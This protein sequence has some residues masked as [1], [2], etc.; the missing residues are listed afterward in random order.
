MQA[1]PGTGAAREGET[2]AP[3]RQLGG[4]H[5]RRGDGGGQI[6]IGRLD[7]MAGD[8]SGETAD[9]PRFRNRSAR[10][11]RPQFRLRRGGRLIALA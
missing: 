7:R 1:N 4:V 3:G 2:V 6:V 9:P 10:G 8:Q 5:V 11:A